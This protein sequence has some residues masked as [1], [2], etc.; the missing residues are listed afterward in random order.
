MEQPTCRA[1][2]KTDHPCPHPAT[3]GIIGE[4]EV[5]EGHRL[6]IE[7]GEDEDNLRDS[8]A[9]LERWIRI[10]DRLNIAPLRKGL[11]TLRDGLGADI[12]GIE[13]K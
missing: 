7:L 5:C 9:H 8:I 1:G 11:R 2:S 13:A 6:L 4:C 3:E 12:S 10:A